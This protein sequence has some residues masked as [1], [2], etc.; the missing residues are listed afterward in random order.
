MTLTLVEAHGITV[1]ALA[2]AR[3]RRCRPISVI[4]LDA[5][6]HPI[7]YQREDRAS[8]FRFDI[9]RAKAMG[10]LGMGADTRELAARAANN[11]PFFNS[12]AAVV[13]GRLALAAGGVLIRDVE[14]NVHGAVGVSGDSAEA[15]EACAHAGIRAVGLSYGVHA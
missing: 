1:A 8:L 15:D 3:A 10:A 11:A 12:L 7:T 5:G 14:G 9:A 4:V 6:G 2:E 13:D